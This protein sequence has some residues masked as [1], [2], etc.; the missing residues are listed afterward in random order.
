MLSKNSTT[1]QED[2]NG[3]DMEKTLTL[4]YLHSWYLPRNLDATNGP[5][6]DKQWRT[7]SN[8]QT[9]DDEM[10]K[11]WTRRYYHLSCQCIGH[12]RRERRY[13]DQGEIQEISNPQILES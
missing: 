1:K 8:K 2:Q 12:V 3:T 5:T 4:A 11:S 13:S 9:A 10:G 6:L 7:A